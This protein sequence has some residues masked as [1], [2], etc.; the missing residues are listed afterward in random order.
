MAKRMNTRRI[1]I[2]FDSGFRQLDPVLSRICRVDEYNVALGYMG[3]GYCVL[4]GETQ[5]VQQF[6]TTYSLA[7]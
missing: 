2:A 6:I 1:C 4:D 7:Q 3:Y 5:G